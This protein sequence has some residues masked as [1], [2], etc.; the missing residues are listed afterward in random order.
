MNLGDS[1]RHMPLWR[2]VCFAPEIIASICVRSFIFIGAVIPSPIS[3]M[4]FTVFAN[5]TLTFACICASS[6]SR[7]THSYA[8]RTD[9]K[10]DGR[11]CSPGRR[12]AP[13]AFSPQLLALP[14]DWLCASCHKFS[15]VGRS[16]SRARYTERE[17]VVP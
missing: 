8:M 11:L 7:P 15:A 13:P 1:H 12:V 2:S 4:R 14:L 17:L 5:A 16:A 3:F 6:R 9:L 10:F